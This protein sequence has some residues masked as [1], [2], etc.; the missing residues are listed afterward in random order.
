MLVDSHCH[1]DY[2]DSSDEVEKII[3]ECILNEVKILNTISTRL[4]KFCDVLNIANKYK[5]IYCTIG[6][7]PD[8]VSEE[9]SLDVNGI[10][11]MYKQNSKIIGV[12]ETGLDFYRQNLNKDLQIDQF[13]K[14]IELADMMKVPV[15][16]H[17]RSADEETLDVISWSKKKFCD[18]VFL[19]HCFTGTEDFALKLID[20]GCFFSISGIVTF[21][22]AQ[23]LQN[24]VKNIIPLDK[25][26][27]E[28]DS[29]F[30]APVPFRG[31]QNRPSYVRHVAEF[32]A[33]IRGV[34][35]VELCNITTS[36]FKKVFTKAIF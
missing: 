13:K 34:D 8:N 31:K 29:P 15:V 33:S 24:I 4:S 18:V 6:N 20:M 11:E 19:M 7:H 14:H 16:V 23:S 28:T 32:I 3:S 25:L 5:N 26:L 12:G 10:Y 17:T 1:L 27:V 36:N 9:D 35:S 21:K 30:L 2:F 22:N